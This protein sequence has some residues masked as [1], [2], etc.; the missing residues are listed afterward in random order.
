M[1]PRGEDTFNVH[2][3]KSKW[4]DFTEAELEEFLNAHLKG[5]WEKDKVGE[6]GRKVV[7]L[8]V[9]AKSEAGTGAGT[10]IACLKW[11]PT[12]PCRSFQDF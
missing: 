4:L 10:E 8:K 12:P 11:C 1:A 7:S 5:K 3:H 6:G 2:L 9:F